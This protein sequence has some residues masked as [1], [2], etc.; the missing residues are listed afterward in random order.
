M[1]HVFCY[2]MS[3][4]RGVGGLEFV[5]RDQFKGSDEKAQ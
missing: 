2:A 5:F 3:V 1:A 4:K